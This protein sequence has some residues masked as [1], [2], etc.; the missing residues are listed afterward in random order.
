MKTRPNIL[1]IYTDQ[2][3]WNALGANGN[4]DIQTPHLDA[5]AA[6]SLN[7]DHAFVQCP[8]CMPS[9]ASFLTGQYPGTLGIPHMGVPVPE[10]T[11]T[12]PKMLKP[13]GYTSANLGKLHF[14][15]H[16][17]RDHRMPYPSYGF[18][19]WEISDEP[20]CYED[21]YFAWVRRQ[22]PESLDKISCGLPPATQVWHE[23]MGI[24]DRITH[25]DRGEWAARAAGVADHLT[26]SAFVADR[27]LNFLSQARDPFFCIASFYSPHSPWIAPQRFFDLYDP[28]TITL[29]ESVLQGGRDLAELRQAHHGYYAM[30][31]EVDH[32]VGQLVAAVPD[33]TVIIFTSDHGEWLGRH[34]R[35]GKGFPGDDS[36]S[37]VPLLLRLPGTGSQR[38]ST[39]VEAIDVIP[40]LLEHIGITPMPHLQGRS[41]LAARPENYGAITEMNDWKA[42][43]TDQFRYIVRSDGKEWLYDLQTD[44]DEQVNIV[45]Q[46]AYA[47]ALST[48]R[49]QLLTRLLHRERPRARTWPY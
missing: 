15:P 21:A 46:P 29:S 41:L 45:E 34:G 17:N 22:S 36:V 9:R 12:L 3:Q 27:T 5:L 38:I 4:P 26:Y 14:L 25:P 30:V 33:D 10:E 47:T 2:Q 40:T 16:A 43:R 32:Y 11:M 23:T 37:R 39:V 31:S 48:H 44:P 20:G 8:V 1:L 24:Q 19:Q 28:S 13:Y 35:Y 6:Q 7:F 18:D 42:L 49:Y